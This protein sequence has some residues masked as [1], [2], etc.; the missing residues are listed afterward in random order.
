MT[1]PAEILERLQ[2]GVGHWRGEEQFPAPDG[3]GTS[4][5]VARSRARMAAG[6]TLLLTDYRQEIDG[7]VVME[8]HS[9]TAWDE[10][11]GAVVMY[12]FDGSGE[13]PTVYRG[14]YEGDALVLE[15]AGPEGT[16][17]R[18]RT[19]RPGPDRMRTVSEFSPDGGRSWSEIFVG[20]YVR[21]G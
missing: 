20:E 13:S 3:A 7:D 11:L 17:I 12:F 14:G 19:T 1:A 16:R 9:V 15:G 8:G 5:A 2:A 6:G 21:E 4:M 18:H 10:S